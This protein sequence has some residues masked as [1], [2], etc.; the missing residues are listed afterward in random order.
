MPITF[1]AEGHPEKMAG[2]GLLPLV[3]APTINNVRVTK[4]LVDGGAGLNLL[5]AKLMEKLQISPEQ[6]LP[7][8]PFQGVNL[9]V[10]QPLG[11]SCTPSPLELRTT[12][13]RRTSL[14]T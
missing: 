9:G 10:T 4:M 1:D 3:V 7:M 8:G 5:S 11:R 6:Q 13:G 2:V 14:L 12:T